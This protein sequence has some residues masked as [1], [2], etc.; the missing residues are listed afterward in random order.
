[1]CTGSSEY[2]DVPAW[3]KEAG[4]KGLEYQY[5]NGGARHW[6][7]DFDD[8]LFQ[9]AHFRLIRELGKRYDG[10]PALGLV[11]IGSVG[12]WGEWHMSGTKV[13][14]TGEDAPLPPLKTRLA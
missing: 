3:L 6:V 10:S 8:P 13:V 4:C 11:D 12:L 14:G 1:M 7:P 2:M 5:G 9:K